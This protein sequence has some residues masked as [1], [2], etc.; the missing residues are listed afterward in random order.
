MAWIVDEMQKSRYWMVRVV[1]SN[2]AEIDIRNV[3]NG[4]AEKNQKRVG[5]TLR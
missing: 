1:M 5:V 4:E 2:E 3:C